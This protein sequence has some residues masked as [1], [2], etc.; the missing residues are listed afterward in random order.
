VIFE[1]QNQAEIS[2]NVQSLAE[3]GLNEENENAGDNLIKTGNAVSLANTFSLVNLNIFRNNWFFLLVNNLG[4]WT[5]RIFGWSAPSA[6]EIPQQGSQIF[7][8]GLNEPTGE[9]EGNVQIEESP[10]LTF[11]NQNQATVNNNIKTRAS[12]G[13]NQANNNQGDTSIQTGNAY[14]LANLFNLVNLNILGGRW[15]M[16]LVNVL[17]NWSG[18]TIFAYP[19]VVVSLTDAPAG[20]SPGDTF[21]YTLSF[22]NQGQDEAEGVRIEFKLPAGL[23]F[24]GDSSGIIPFCLEQVCS[25]DI[26]NLE[27][28]QE[29]SFKIQVRLEPNFSSDQISSLLEMFI[30]KAYAAEKEASIIVNASIETIDPESDTG[31]NSAQATTTVYFPSIGSGQDLRQPVLEISA[32][33]NVNEFVHPGDT[34]TFEITVKNKSDVPSYNTR[35]VQRLYNGAPEDFG[36]AEFYL[37]TIEPGKGGKLSFGLK[38]ANDGLLPAG[39]YRTVAQAF[40]TA[41]NGNEVSSNEARTYFEIRRAISSLFEARA[42]GKEEG[43]ILGGEDTQCPKTEDI[44]PY[45]LLLILSSSYL[46]NWVRP[47]LEKI[48]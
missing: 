39:T 46:V 47:K 36:T 21:E 22:K 11:Q 5:G 34:V 19:D 14:S 41:P 26:G 6:Q 28:G 23:T 8:L 40:G 13:Q 15:F 9:I 12:T 18:N 31:N 2:D 20:V 45:I 37:G 25:W 1:N 35:L 30:P 42:V 38:L 48:K 24:L 29:G 16:G 4:N 7:E 27:A 32:W 33:N 17:G 43:E 44:L 3:T 10:P